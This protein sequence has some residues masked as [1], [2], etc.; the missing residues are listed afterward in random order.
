MTEE[1][2]LECTIVVLE[3][4]NDDT[5]KELRSFNDDPNFIRM[6]ETFKKCNFNN[7]MVDF[8]I[9]INKK[10]NFYPEPLWLKDGREFFADDYLKPGKSKAKL[11]LITTVRD[12]KLNEILC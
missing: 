12:I 8:C 1:Q 5:D 6:N 9:F 10:Y 2:I 7:S 3:F 11:M 4:L